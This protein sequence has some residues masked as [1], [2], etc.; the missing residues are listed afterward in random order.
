[1]L[2]QIFNTVCFS[3]ILTQVTREDEFLFHDVRVSTGRPDRGAQHDL[4]W[5]V[6]AHAAHPVPAG[7]EITAQHLNMLPQLLTASTSA[8]ERH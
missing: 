7:S 5:V 2:A 1:M 6:A 4:L 3:S 8:H